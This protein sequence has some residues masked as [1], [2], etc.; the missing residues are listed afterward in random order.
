MARGVGSSL[1]TIVSSLDLVEYTPCRVCV[2]CPFVVL[3]DGALG[4]FDEGA[5]GA[6]DEG[7]FGALVEGA[8]GILGALDDGVLVDFGNVCKFLP[9]SR[10]VLPSVAMKV[11]STTSRAR[12]NMVFIV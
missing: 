9:D 7:V 3:T 8:L 2:R 1:W 11:H 4:A 12:A 5:L 10:R 6:L